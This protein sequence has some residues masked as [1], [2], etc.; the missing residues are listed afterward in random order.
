MIRF[1]CGYCKQRIGA[2]EKYANQKRLCPK[3]KKPILIPGESQESNATN[4]SI[5]K[6]RCPSCNQKIGVTTDYAGKRVRCSKCK[7]PLQVPDALGIESPELTSGAVGE[8]SN[9]FDDELTQELLAAEASSSE[10]EPLRL[11]PETPREPSGWNSGLDARNNLQSFNTEAIE[12][13]SSGLAKSLCKIPLSIGTSIG[14]T[15]GAAILWTIIASLIGL[16]WL[17]F[18]C[19]PVAGAA[20]YGLVLFTENRNLGLGLLAALIGLFG[21]FCGKV[22][23][24]KWVVLP[25]MENPFAIAGEEYDKSTLEEE[26]I[27]EQLEDPKSLFRAVCFQL[28]ENGEFEQEFAEKVVQANYDGRAPIGEA[29][30]VQEGMSKV[31][32]AVDSWDLEQK[33]EAII[34]QFERDK[35]MFKNFGKELLTSVVDS[36]GEEL[37]EGVRNTARETQ[38]L[39]EGTR[40]IQETKIGFAFAFIGSFCFLDLLF[41]PVGMWGAYKIGAGKD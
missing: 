12:D 3:C 24:A 4:S 13:E 6:F 15:V 38:E 7:S 23:L 10:I 34:A 33:R 14:F 40:T 25:Q 27:Q 20:G 21:I 36:N 2:P 41:I 39:F 5:I 28:A 17:H 16:S 37:P 29:K 1:R 9:A 11:K 19:I 35:Q 32:K 26:Q 31:E 18:L 30:Q 8:S 22:F